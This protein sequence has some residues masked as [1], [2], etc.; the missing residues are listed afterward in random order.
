MAAMSSVEM[1]QARGQAGG[2]GISPR[3]AAEAARLPPSLA[4]DIVG[5]G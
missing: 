4:R 5:L 1:R 2:A 3:V